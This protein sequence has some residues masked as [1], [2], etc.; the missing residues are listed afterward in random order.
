MAG[1]YVLGA[2]ERL[3][4]EGSNGHLGAGPPARHPVSSGP[5][6][7]RAAT[8]RKRE[9]SADKNQQVIVYAFA[10]FY[11][12]ILTLGWLMFDKVSS[13]DFFSQSALVLAAIGLYNAPPPR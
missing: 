8:P 2:Q 7:N 6:R 3:P 9:K 5:R 4:V 11:M 1:Q 12:V 10:A 13:G